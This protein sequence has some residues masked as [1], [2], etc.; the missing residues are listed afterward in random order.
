MRKIHVVQSANEIECLGNTF[1]STWDTK[2][3]LFIPKLIL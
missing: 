3:S 2:Y 1:L